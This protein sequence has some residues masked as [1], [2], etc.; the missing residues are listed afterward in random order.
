[1][2]KEVEELERRKEEL[3][4]LEP[5]KYEIHEEIKNIESQIK[6][7]EENLKILQEAQRI[8]QEGKLEEEKININIK[9]K[10]ELEKTK[11]E[12]EKSLENVKDVGEKKK[13]S[14]FLYF[15]PLIILAATITL[16]AL[17]IIAFGVVSAIVSAIS[18]AVI[19]I[20][21]SKKDK[22]YKKELEEIRR[23]K[24]DILNKIELINDEI[25]S[26]ENKI[27][28]DE[29]SKNL[30]LKNQLEEL[31]VKYQDLDKINLDESIDKAKIINK[32]NYINNLKLELSKKEFSE[33]N[34]INELEELTKLE[35]KLKANK[36]NLNELL[37]YNDAIEIAKEALES[38]YKE[39]K[40]S[41]TP[42]FTENLSNSINMI[43]DGRYKNVKVNEDN[44]LSLETESGNY[45]TANVLS[46]GTIDQ[47]YLSLRISSIDELS[48]ENMPIIL[49]ETFAYFD[50]NR[51]EN[52][53]KFLSK[54]Y[55]NKQII[56]LTCTNREI[57]VLEGIDRIGKKLYN[58]CNL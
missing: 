21:K 33:K 42:K 46:V 22:Q 30:K 5:R 24:K 55:E 45:V 48:P 43:T 56:I 47:L 36:E 13:I 19:F 50:K 10:E 6:D 1:M 57:E 35:E 3:E 17:G 29:E 12:L 38:S 27:Q 37:E 4:K 51:L 58:I 20:F 31:K 7:E 16:F 40:E 44:G 34:T 28:E 53:L 8:Q 54:E 49:D 9:A 18:F 14:L 26:K 2:T 32:Q 11:S 39:M 25:K 52:V 15:V 41:I 23:E